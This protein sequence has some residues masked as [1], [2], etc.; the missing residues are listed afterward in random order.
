MHTAFGP[1]MVPQLSSSLPPE[2]LLE[3][4]SGTLRRMASHPREGA[5]GGD[6]AMI[7]S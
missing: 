7:S 5:G 1:Q 6:I 3:I 2:E 4:G